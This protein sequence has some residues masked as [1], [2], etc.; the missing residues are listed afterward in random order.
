MY[1]V[2]LLASHVIQYQ[3]PFYR[4]LA[5]HPELDLTVFY[6]SRAGA[7]TYHDAEMQTTL[8]WDVDLLAGYR[9]VFLRNFGRGEGWAR[10]V[11]PGIVPQ[12]LFGR[13]DAAILFLGWGTITSLLALAACRMRGLPVFVYGDS[14]EIP[15]GG[16]L[17]HGLRR[18]LFA[19]VDGFLV[20]GNTNADYYA[21]FGADRRRFFSVPWAIDNDRFANESRFAPG[22]RAAL[23]ARFGADDDR[24][25]VIY[26]AKLL[27]RKDPMTLLRA[28]DAMRHRARTTVVFLG[29]GA[30]RDELEA[31]AR[32]RGLDARFPGFINQ[33]D[34]PRH[35]AMGDVFVLPSTYEPRGAV[36]NEAMA[37]GLP[38]IATSASGSA[39]DI[40]RDGD[41]GFVFEAGDAA[42]LARQL[43]ALAEDRA[44]RARMGERSRE[45]IAAWDYAAGVRGVLEALRSTC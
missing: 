39:G 29:H 15:R 20:S 27:P 25:V 30:L 31:F 26:S 33:R 44:L 13:Y 19:L 34:L 37:C 28:V 16:S 23:R 2:A 5:A 6:G 12:L 32:A 24:F 17:A 7:E 42:T 38:V 41:N 43:D 35:Y 22:E 9:H 18:A 45:I 4:L 10:L 14:N 36:V 21:H 40:V 1:R 3:A 11:N 8:Q